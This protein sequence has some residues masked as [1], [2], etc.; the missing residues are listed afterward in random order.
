MDKTHFFSPVLVDGHLNF[1]LFL[2]LVNLVLEHL[3]SNF[4]VVICF[5][6]PEYVP[7]RGNDE[8]YGNS[9][10]SIVR[11]WQTIYQMSYTILHSY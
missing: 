5:A 7:K 10:F 1:Y 6:S 2:V 4:C 11:N 3:C 8:S 9:G